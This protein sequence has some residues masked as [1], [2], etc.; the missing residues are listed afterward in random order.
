MPKFKVTFH[1]VIQ[2]SQVFGSNDEHMV[3]RVF[4]SLEVDGKRPG[5]F[6]AD[7]KQA[8]GNE[9]TSGFAP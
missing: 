2:D 1:E 3:S 9:F 7:L 8:V 4:F 6:Y 5:D